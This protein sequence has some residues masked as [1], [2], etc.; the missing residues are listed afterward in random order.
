MMN[1][2]VRVICPDVFSIYACILSSISNGFSR[3]A[4][5]DEMTAQC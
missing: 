3:I 2:T 4:S 5:L 1:M